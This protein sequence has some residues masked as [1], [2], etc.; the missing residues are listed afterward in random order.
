MFGPSLKSVEAA[1]AAVAV[2][3]DEAVK[4]VKADWLIA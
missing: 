4:V 2:K 3:S 1:G